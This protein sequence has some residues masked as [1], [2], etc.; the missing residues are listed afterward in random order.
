MYLLGRGARLLPSTAFTP[1]AAI[2]VRRHVEMK[3]RSR[4]DLYIALIGLS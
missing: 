3:C 4:E 1:R 2:A